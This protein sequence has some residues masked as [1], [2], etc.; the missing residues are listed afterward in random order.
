MPTVPRKASCRCVTY[1]LIL[2]MGFACL[3]V[4]VTAEE[5]ARFNSGDL[6]GTV[7]VR[8]WFTSGNNG[9][10]FR[11]PVQ[12]LASSPVVRANPLSELKWRGLDSFVT[13]FYGEVFYKRFGLLASY[14]FG[15]IDNGTLN[16]DDFTASGG[17]G[18]FSHTRSGVNDDSLWRFDVDFAF[19]ALQWDKP[20]F[21]VGRAPETV[22]KG[23][24]DVL[25]G[26]Q[27]W[28]EQYVAFGATGFQCTAAF[29]GTNNCAAFG[30]ATIASNVKALTQEY[31]WRSIRLGARARLPVLRDLDVNASI[32]GAPFVWMEMD[33]VHHLRTDLKHN[34][35][36]FS[37]SEN[38]W[39]IECDASLSYRL[40]K[41]LFADGGFR[42]S[43]IDSGEGNKF[44]HA[45]SGTT[46][47]RLNSTTFE[48]YGP[49]ISLNYRW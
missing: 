18:R 27:Y 32:M 49:H 4:A 13:E 43:R 24:V 36:F 40:W 1:L 6:S 14:G 28:Q 37:R 15:N 31:R 22:Q 16:D 35:S 47:D 41:G 23:F 5:A 8:E 34:P 10:S 17:Q 44:T 12:L 11:G 38:G 39:G 46:M 29:V 26:Y 7:G 48:R 20:L 21:A 2:L 25:G 45:L 9:W 3:P 42:Y 30:P 19:H 33:D